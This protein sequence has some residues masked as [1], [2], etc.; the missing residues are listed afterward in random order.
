MA[1]NQT[2]ITDMKDAMLEAQAEVMAIV[3]E[4]MAEILTPQVKIEGR[5]LWASMPPEVKEQFKAE[6]P[7]EYQAFR[8]G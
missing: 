6:R 5:K 2:S 3:R 8:K 7:A 1:N 4:V